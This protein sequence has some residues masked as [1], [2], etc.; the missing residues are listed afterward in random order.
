M[1]HTVFS[2]NNGEVSPYLRHRIDFDKTESSAEVMRNFIPNV[3]GGVT[4]RPGL[5]H[6]A[7]LVNCTFNS[8]AL[9]FIGSDGSKYI[10]HFTPGLLTVYNS[11]GE[12]R[13]QFGWM[14]GYTFPATETFDDSLRLI[15]IVQLN[16]IAYL[17]HPGIY[18]QQL[19]RF[20]D[21]NWTLKFVDFS[22][23]PVLDENIDETKRLSV[24]GNPMEAP[25]G[26]GASYAVGAKV[27]NSSAWVCHT[28]HNAVANTQPGVGSEWT[29]YWR[30]NYYRAGEP[31]TIT[32]INLG[33]VAW[34]ETFEDYAEG[35]VV[36]T[37][38]QIIVD[39]S[40]TY[41]TIRRWV[42]VTFTNSTGVTSPTA[43]YRTYYNS[44]GSVNV[45]AYNL[46]S[47][48]DRVNIVSLYKNFTPMTVGQTRVVTLPAITRKMDI[49]WRKAGDNPLTAPLQIE[50]ITVNVP[51]Q[52]ITLVCAAD[53]VTYPLFDYPD[54]EQSND[55]GNVTPGGWVDSVP[56]LNKGTRNNVLW[57]YM[58][59]TS[60]P[61][62]WRCK[63]A[64]TSSTD[65]TPPMSGSNPTSN[66]NWEEVDMWYWR[67]IQG[68]IY[69]VGDLVMASG[70]IA[71]QNPQI[72]RCIQAHTLT[73][74]NAVTTC[75][76]AGVVNGV[77]FALG[78]TASSFW[79]LT[80]QTIPADPVFDG[81]LKI[82]NWTRTVPYGIGR[83]IMD[84]ATNKIYYATATH[85]PT[86]ANKPGQ[87]NAPWSLQSP[88][89]YQSSFIGDGVCPGL[90]YK[91]TPKR[92]SG[93]F[94]IQL[95]ATSANNNVS[96]APIAVQGDWFIFT[97][98]TWSG[99]FYIESSD[100]NG[101]TWEVI[102]SFESRAD[103]NVSDGGSSSTPVLLRLRWSYYANGSSN[104]RAVLI[105]SDDGITGYA[106]MDTYVN[107]TTMTGIAKTPMI[108]GAT[109][110][111]AEGAFTPNNGFPRAIGFHES[112]LVYAGTA[113]K[114]VSLWVSQTDDL[115]NFQTGANDDQGMY[116]TLAL[117]YSSPINW[118][119]SQRRLLVGTKFAEWQI[120]SE[121]QDAPLTPSNFVA[122]QGSSYGTGS[123]AP[124]SGGDAFIFAEKNG[125]RLRDFIF[126][127]NAK[128]YAGTDLCRM[129]EHLFGVNGVSNMAWQQNR[130]PGLWVCRRDGILLHMIYAK[131]EKVMAWS[132]H[133]SFNGTIQAL[134]LD[135]VIFSGAGS[136]D[137]VFFV[138]RR[139]IG[140]STVT[141]LERF[142][143]NWQSTMEAGNDPKF[144]DGTENA[145][146]KAELRTLP[147]DAQARDGSSTLG[148][149]KR[150]HKAS[151]S[152][153]KSKGGFL[154]N[155]NL[156]NKQIITGTTA[157]TGWVD[158]VPDGGSL[159]DLQLNMEHSTD[160]AFILR[161]AVIRYQTN[162]R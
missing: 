17:V 16:D 60:R 25:W 33:E 135:V 137:D 28:A 143:S 94:Q 95:E 107:A 105:P 32:G 42:T 51:E 1:N 54:S 50:A 156:A 84:S 47:S 66:A 35:D 158:V 75:P 117:S 138:V 87:P 113:S 3:Y 37:G 30:R 68:K 77:A 123:I 79:N 11:S 88:T 130:E 100:N 80:Y 93:D 136:D 150:I 151:V 7:A 126:D 110:E 147:V 132:R 19:T 154:W 153:L 71:G 162:E 76:A 59:Y 67:A 144:T 81:F 2:F 48:G 62:T 142:A 46:I 61:L 115:T 5:A 63:V 129:A 131:N 155:S 39:T 74:A 89:G 112:R 124:V 157:T 145:L 122:R 148:Y 64:V 43:E 92:D 120:G 70:T 9:P 97:Y 44:D 24:A 31:V 85:F 108:S 128:G 103:R 29:K 139:T 14:V 4:K 53:G 13:A 52:A 99:V 133:D 118:V 22:R 109:T 86:Q 141:R 159:D 57:S 23:A 38:G 111:W 56:Q 104:P 146:V 121:S 102:R 140:G 161:C 20:S 127:D 10:L 45:G 41:V 69:A 21:F 91:I 96:S 65:S 152:L 58:G 83:R 40:A 72:Y 82:E 98:G 78:A 55:W 27:F 101:I 90:T 125:A 12:Y 116:A 149:R 18:P 15:Q 26:L 106:L 73:S 134:I 49:R 119:A 114:P 36:T 8:R 34:A 160:G 6:V